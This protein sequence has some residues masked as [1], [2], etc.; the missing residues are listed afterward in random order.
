MMSEEHKIWL[1]KQKREQTF[2]IF[3]RWLLVL[4]F[5][6]GWQLLANYGLINTF[7]FSSP[8]RIINTLI[9]LSNSGDLWHHIGITLQ[10]L[11]ISFGLGTILGILIASLMWWF[12]RFAKI[13]DPYLT[14][15]N[16]LPKVALGP[17]IIIWVG[18]GMGAIILMALLISLIITII[19]VYNNFNSTDVNKIR[20]LKTFGANKWQVFSKV[21]IP[22]NYLGIVSALKINISMCLIGIIMGELLV[23]RAGIGYLIM[24]GSQVFNLDLV[25]TG[26]F[27]LGV[28][29][30]GLY[31]IVSAIEKRLN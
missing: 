6:G 20:L 26:V 17:I 14:I 15:I 3:S 29:S 31:Y 11:I 30:A 5:L 16:S 12:P 9:S 18:A 10:E 4:I 7:I 13:I 27:I 28:I 23:S 8:E 25:I 21:I 1:K 24:F 22:S 19:N 2:I